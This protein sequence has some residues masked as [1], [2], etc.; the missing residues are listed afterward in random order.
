MIMKQPSTGAGARN[1][2]AHTLVFSQLDS[3]FGAVID[4]VNVTQ[5]DGRD[6]LAAV[7]GLMAGFDLAPA[8]FASEAVLVLASSAPAAKQA[9]TAGMFGMPVGGVNHAVQLWGDMLLKRHG[10]KA[11]AAIGGPKAS[12]RATHFGYSTTGFYHH[13][14]CDGLVNCTTWG[15]TLLQ[16]HHDLRARGVPY[17]WMLIDRY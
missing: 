2:S 6:T 8:G 11:R 14:Q 16:V 4:R 10:G 5:P 13:N 1:P 3:F 7:A 17:R 12:V 9:Q 15:D